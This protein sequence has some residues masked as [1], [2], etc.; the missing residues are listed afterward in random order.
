MFR[1]SVRVATIAT[2]A[3]A[4]AIAVLTVMRSAVA[5]DMPVLKSGLWEVA[6]VTDQQQDKRRVTT[7]CLDET[8]QASMHD[9]GLGVAKELCSQSDRRFDGSRL[10]I[11]ATC[12]LGT[13]T[14]KSHSVMVFNGNTSYHTD[15]EASYDPK[16][17]GASETKSTL[18]GKWT[19]PCK[20]GQQ[21]GDITFD[22]GKT[23]NIKTII[24]K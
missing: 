10:T 8:V 21:P 14:M 9:F 18:D 22:N 17:M 2:F 11:D 5:A 24:N 20:Q 15:S 13:T 1:P 12:K 7:M 6:Q 23:I 4:A 3:T 16:F 19:G